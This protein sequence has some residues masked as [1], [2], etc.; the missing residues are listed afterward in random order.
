LIIIII[1][2][3]VIFKCRLKVLLKWTELT[4]LRNRSA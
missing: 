1:S 4:K 3:N 2:V